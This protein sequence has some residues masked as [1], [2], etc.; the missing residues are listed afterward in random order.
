MTDTGA[1]DEDIKQ[2]DFLILTVTD[3]SFLVVDKYIK[4]N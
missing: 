4:I 3:F 2:I 1:M